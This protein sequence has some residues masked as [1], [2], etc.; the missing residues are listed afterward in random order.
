MRIIMGL[1][2]TI[3]NSEQ[4]LFKYDLVNGHTAFGSTIADEND[5][6]QRG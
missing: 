1:N 6:I 3:H 5:K 2:I 4:L